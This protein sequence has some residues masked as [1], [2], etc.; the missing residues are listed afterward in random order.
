VEPEASALEETT[1]ATE[2]RA[3]I[4]QITRRLDALRDRDPGPSRGIG[5]G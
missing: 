5:M 2:Q 3:K 4:D 1:A